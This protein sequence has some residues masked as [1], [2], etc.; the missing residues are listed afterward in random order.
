MK[1]LTDMNGV[2][3]GGAYTFG[4][5]YKSSKITDSTCPLNDIYWFRS[6]VIDDIA[7]NMRNLEYVEYQDNII[8]YIKP[9]KRD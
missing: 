8:N 3:L 7:I 9:F 4:L 1:K 2:V 5:N 6:K